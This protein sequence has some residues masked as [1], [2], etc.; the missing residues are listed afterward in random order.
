MWQSQSLD[1]I[2][3]YRYASPLLLLYQNSIIHVT[4]KKITATIRNVGVSPYAIII[5][6]CFCRGM[7]MQKKYKRGDEIIKWSVKEYAY[8]IRRWSQLGLVVILQEKNDVRYVRDGLWCP[9]CGYRL[10]TRPRNSKFK[11]ELRASNEID[12]AKLSVIYQ[13]L[14]ACYKV[15]V[16]KQ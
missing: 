6:I 2:T 5:A 16:I 12:K 15:E 3:F 10:R 9:C 14:P 13:Q 11:A 8:V 1:Q 4:L 7:I